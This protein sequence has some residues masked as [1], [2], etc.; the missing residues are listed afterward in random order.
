MKYPTFQTWI[1]FTSL[2]RSKWCKQLLN[3]SVKFF[4]WYFNYLNVKKRYFH[5]RLKYVIR[6]TYNKYAA[7]DASRPIK[8]QEI[9]L[10]RDKNWD[11]KK[12]SFKQKT[13]E[14]SKSPLIAKRASKKVKK[15]EENLHQ[16]NLHEK[17]REGEQE[18]D[19]TKKQ[20]QVML[21]SSFQ[22]LSYRF[23]R[24]FYDSE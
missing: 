12:A 1:R 22:T 17:Q 8:T 18:E 7:R 3:S 13:T 9:Y 15:S 6:G 4:A 21:L 23:I 19:L 20:K 2:L 11:W 10:K 16:K 5:R 14:K 24:S